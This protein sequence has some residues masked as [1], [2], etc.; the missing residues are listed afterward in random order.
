MVCRILLI[1][2]SEELV[3][4]ALDSIII[5]HRRWTNIEFI[6]L[7][8]CIILQTNCQQI[9][10]VLQSLSIL[11]GKCQKEWRYLIIK[12]LNPILANKGGETLPISKMWLPASKRRLEYNST[13]GWK[14][15]RGHL[16]VLWI[17]I[18]H[19]P[20]H[21]AHK[22]WGWKIGKPRL[23]FWEVATSHSGNLEF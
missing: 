13:F 7:L 4:L 15:P 2:N 5:S 6:E 18:I 10:K 8:I 9:I 11:Q 23:S 14:T 20:A 16:Y 12:P 17:F 1:L 21:Y 19:N 3:E 22:H